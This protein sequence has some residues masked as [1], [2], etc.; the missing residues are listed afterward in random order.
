MADPTKTKP[1][2]ST[3]IQP[4]VAPTG[5]TV[6]QQT[7]LPPYWAADEEVHKAGV[8]QGFYARVIGRDD[9]DPT[10]PRYVVQAGMDTPCM[11][12]GGD[13]AEPVIVKKGEFFTTSVYAGLPLE[14]FIGVPVIVKVKDKRKINTKGGP[15]TIWDFTVEV[16]PQVDKILAAR[17]QA[18]AERAIAQGN[19]LRAGGVPT[20]NGNVPQLP[21]GGGMD[22]EIPF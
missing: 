17:R 20:T 22:D 4:F 9:G 7:G 2:T 16:T 1:A 19:A 6:K 15:R 12:G 21:Q 18:A 8:A 13:D 3:A 11:K 5:E 10:F 14:R